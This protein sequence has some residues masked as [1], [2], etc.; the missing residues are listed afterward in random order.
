MEL[1]R[2]LTLRRSRLKFSSIASR[3]VVGR[4]SAAYRGSGPSFDQLENWKIVEADDGLA[5]PLERGVIERAL[6]AVDQ[7]GDIDVRSRKV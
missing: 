2:Q 4:L 5:V 3:E 6:R 7:L 1:R